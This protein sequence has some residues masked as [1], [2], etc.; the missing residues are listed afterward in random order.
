MRDKMYINA[1]V[2][3]LFVSSA[4]L[5]ITYTTHIYVHMYYFAPLTF[6]LFIERTRIL[7]PFLCVLHAGLCTA[8]RRPA[9]YKTR[10]RI[11]LK[12]CKRCEREDTRLLSHS[13]LS[14]IRGET[15]LYVCVC[16]QCMRHPS[17]HFYFV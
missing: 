8:R 17:E 2:I 11:S 10:R 3:V 7:H 9:E 15:S 16:V 5:S 6:Y 4:F 1:C 12:M 14:E 13:F